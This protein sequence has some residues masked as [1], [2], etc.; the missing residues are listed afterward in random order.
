ME[1][2]E[3]ID[4]R[5]LC[6]SLGEN[7]SDVRSQDSDFDDDLRESHGSSDDT[8]DNGEVMISNEFSSGNDGTE[9]SGSINDG[10]GADAT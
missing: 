10:N 4:E 7:A 5:T 2:P 3:R 8:H 6:E 1:A 9:S